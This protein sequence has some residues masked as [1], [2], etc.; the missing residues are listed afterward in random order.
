MA[1]KPLFLAIFAHAVARDRDADGPFGG[2]AGTLDY[3]KQ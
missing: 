3:P 2:D 1:R